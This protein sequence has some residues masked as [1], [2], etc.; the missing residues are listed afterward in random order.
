MWEH[1]F[2]GPILLVAGG[3]G[4]VPMRSML[5]HWAN[6]KHE[7]TRARLL[8]S[9]RTLDDVIYRR[10][11]EQLGG[12]DNV[13]VDIALTREWPEDWHGLRGRIDKTALESAASAPSEPGLTYICG[14]TPF[15]EAVSSTLVELGQDAARIKTERFG[16][17]GT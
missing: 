1:A 7:P 9:A 10:E 15:V 12:L 6:S 14:P 5:R 13:D 3:S 17:T 11:L 8:Y 2:G 16:P 4:V